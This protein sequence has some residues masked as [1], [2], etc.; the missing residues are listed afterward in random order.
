[1][2]YEGHAFGREPGLVTITRKDGTPIPY[3][4]R[5]SVGDVAVIDALH[6]EGPSACGNRNRRRLRGVR[7]RRGQRRAGALS[8]R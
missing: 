7:L 6:V 2:H 1:M 8:R 5:L 4:S 3:N